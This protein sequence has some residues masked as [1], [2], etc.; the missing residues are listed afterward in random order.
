MNKLVLLFLA[1]TTTLNAQVFRLMQVSSLAV[2]TCFIPPYASNLSFDGFDKNVQVS[3][4]PFD[5]ERTDAFS[6]GCWV[7]PNLLGTRYIIG[8]AV[9]GTGVGYQI[10][11]LSN[12]FR[13]DIIGTGGFNPDSISK[14]SS[15]SVVGSTWQHIFVTYD[16]SSNASGFKIYYN[17]SLDSSTTNKDVL[18]TS[19]LNNEVFE[20][21]ERNGGL[22]WSGEIADARFY[23]VEKTATDVS[24]IYNCTNPDETGLVGH[25]ILNE[26][27]GITATDSS[28]NGNDGIIN[29]A[30]WN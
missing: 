16:G 29:G 25:W 20:I 19:I 6:Y 30:T 12:K 9:N 17:G 18:S 23:S 1:M 8:K 11:T 13:C 21:G 22:D 28:G 15:A 7:K 26:G 2:V 3:D 27:S 10:I 24:N 14:T 4:S 5:F